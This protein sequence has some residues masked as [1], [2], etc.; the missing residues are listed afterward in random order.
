MTMDVVNGVSGPRAS[1]ELTI[2]RSPRRPPTSTTH[3]I[4][5]AERQ[6][7][8]RQRRSSRPRIVIRWATP[9]QAPA[10]TLRRVQSALRTREPATLPTGFSRSCHQ[11]RAV[12]DLA[13][14]LV[15]LLDVSGSMDG[16]PLEHLKAV[17]TTLI[18]SLDDDDRLEM[19]AFSS[20]QVRYRAEPVHATEAE[21]RKA[22][23]WIKSS[24]RTAVRN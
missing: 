12:S 4:A 3:S 6:G 18:D 23:A 21:R 17:V 15:L 10:L 20:E 9:R 2:R 16:R 11:S 1:V 22:C 5:G 13:R 7:D 19:V 14:D 8:A 24:G